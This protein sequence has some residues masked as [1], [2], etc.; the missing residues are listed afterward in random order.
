MQLI[1]K[2]KR[3]IFAVAANASGILGLIS[4]LEGSKI[5]LKDGGGLSLVPSQYNLGIVTSLFPETQII[6]ENVTPIE[7]FD[8]TDSIVYIPKTKPREHQTRANT[9]MQHART[10]ALFMAPGTGKT[11]SAIDRAAQLFCARR[12]SGMIVIAPKGVHNQW[13]FAQFPIH[14][15]VPYIALAWPIKAFPDE[16]CP[17]PDALKVLSVGWDRATTDIGFNLIAEFIRWHRGRV[18]FVGDESHV[19]KNP[20]TQRWKATQALARHCDYRL[21]LTG[22]PLAKDL[23]DVWGQLRLL[24]EN[25]LGIR[26]RTSFENEYCIMGGY[27][28]RDVVGYRNLERFLAKVAPYVFSI[29]RAEIGMLPP[30]RSPW[31]FSMSKT[32]KQMIKAIKKDLVYNMDNG[33]SDLTAEN[34]AVAI[35]KAQQIASGFYIDNIDAKCNITRELFTAE[36]N[37]RMQALLQLIDTIDVSE[38]IVIWSRF[39]YDAKK[40]VAV[41]GAQRCVM[42]VGGMTGEEQS[43]AI[44][45]FQVNPLRRFFVSNPSAGGTG[46]DGLQIVCSNDIFYSHSTNFIH[47]TQAEARI[48]RIGGA[49]IVN[50]FD[51]IGNGCFDKRI[52][53]SLK[54]KEM[55]SAIAFGDLRGWLEEDEEDNPSAYYF[56][57]NTPS[58]AEWE[59]TK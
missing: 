2:E 21:I 16:L 5:W 13:I 37:P 42:Y 55:M 41:L 47:R 8:A 53:R 49:N 23:K 7:E 10:F 17:S 50:H 48:E 29:T 57:S 12:I 39:R 19:A 40:I 38:K 46:I 44:R 43:N 34:V 30:N 22:T 9:A 15:G 4:R 11:K 18:L 28:R 45:E 56:E 6:H 36:D 14:C 3:A 35:M 26:Y 25:I 54:R 33:D 58:D 27:E 24:D 31:L 20:S 1:I 51:L 32:Q 59:I 52:I